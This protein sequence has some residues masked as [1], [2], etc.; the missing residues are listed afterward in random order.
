MQIKATLSTVGFW[1]LGL[2]KPLRRLM[3]PIWLCCITLIGHT[4]VMNPQVVS[5][6]LL[7]SV[8]T[9]ADASALLQQLAQISVQQLETA[10]TTDAARMAFWINIYNAITA[11]SLGQDP[12]QY[13]NRQR[14]FKRQQIQL[15]DA[16]LSLN[17][18]EHGILRRSRSLISLGY[19]RQWFRKKTN[20]RLQV[21]T[22]DYRIHFALNCGAKSC[23]P[24]AFYT[25]NRL[26]SQLNLATRGFLKANVHLSANASKV[27]VPRILGWFRADFGGKKGILK[28]LH[29]TG[30]L[31]P[32]AKPSIGFA[33]Y[34]W[35]LMPKNFE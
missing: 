10:L 15:A 7:M 9:G 27:Q 16:T 24:I 35:D 2:V 22:L 17:D 34:N 26:Q 4:Q 23:P 3:W 32:S 5:Q 6:N 29:T 11:Y 30:V 13:R 18:V 8:K 21:D 19:A 31:P 33:P 28:L 1:A 12:G 20:L 25:P 14:F